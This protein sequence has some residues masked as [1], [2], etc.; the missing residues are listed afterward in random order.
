MHI[1]SWYLY[2]KT[3]YIA[4]VVQKVEKIYTILRTAF[5][6]SK[7]FVKILQKVYISGRAEVVELSAANTPCLVFSM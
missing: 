5:L 1:P 4:V 2:I 6:F 3:T 7:H